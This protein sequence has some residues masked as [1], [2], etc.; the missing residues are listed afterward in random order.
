MKRYLYILLI[1]I[2]GSI[3][4]CTHNNGDIGDWFGTWILESIYIDNGEIPSGYQGNIIF[5]FQSDIISICRVD[6]ENH[7][8]ENFYGTWSHFDDTLTLNFTYSDDRFPNPGTGMYAPPKETYIPAG[9]T[10]MS[11]LKLSSSAI[12]LLY[13][14]PSGRVI[15]YNLKKWG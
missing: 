10:E 4:S 9:I 15:L 6:D 3:S 5:K 1:A 14:S 2:V 12:E 11:V 8:S 13:E 7:S